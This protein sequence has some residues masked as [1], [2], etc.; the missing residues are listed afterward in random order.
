MNHLKDRITYELSH[1]DVD[2]ELLHLNFAKRIELCIAN[3]GN[4]AEKV[5]C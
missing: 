1:I 2:V 4:F 5:I 3:D